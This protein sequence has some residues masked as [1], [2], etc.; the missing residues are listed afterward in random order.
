MELNRY[1][2]FTRL[3]FFLEYVSALR[4]YMY[5]YTLNEQLIL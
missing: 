4:V 5:V 1:V 3:Y 2:D